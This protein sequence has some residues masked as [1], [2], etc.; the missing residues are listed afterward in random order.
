MKKSIATL[1]SRVLTLTLATL[2]ASCGGGGGAGI[3]AVDMTPTV[4]NPPT[5]AAM[6]GPK[7]EIY[8]YV[9][10]IRLNGGFGAL[11]ADGRVEAAAQAH[12]DYTTTNFY[13]SGVPDPIL[14]TPTST[15]SPYAHVEESTWPGFT[16]V[17]PDDRLRAAGYQPLTSTEV[18]GSI[19]GTSVGAEPDIKSCVDGL[20]GTVFHRAALLDTSLDAFGLGVGNAVKDANGYLLRACVFNLASQSGARSLPTGWVGIVPYAGQTG[21]ATKMSNEVPDPTP[22]IAVEGYPVSLQV[23]SGYTVSVNLF[24]LRESAGPQLEGVVL[25]RT[26]TN[27]LRANEA[28]FVPNG[29]LRTNTAYTATF[30]GNANSTQTGLS[31]FPVSETWT[32]TTGA[33]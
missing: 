27:Y 20:I 7:A 25:T 13:T 4:P 6:T 11:T 16:G 30:T 3:T 24:T 28:Y 26:Q 15:G 14:H 29:A 2:L 8:G 10:Q 22:S 12:A 33:Q 5:P 31:G 9:N 19:Y 21:V 1:A 32:F 18:S 23:P 17:S